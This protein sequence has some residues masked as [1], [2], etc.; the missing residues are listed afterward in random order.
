MWHSPGVPQSKF[1]LSIQHQHQPAA[2]KTTFEQAD[3]T[4]APQS[5]PHFSQA[6]LGHPM[7]GFD[8]SNPYPKATVHPRGN[9]SMSILGVT[10]FSLPSQPS[11]R[12]LHQ[13]P[14]TNASLD[15]QV[16]LLATLQKIH[17]GK[18]ALDEWAVSIQRIQ[19]KRPNQTDLTSAQ[20]IL[21]PTPTHDPPEP[22]SNSAHFFPKHRPHLSPLLLSIDPETTPTAC[23]IH[24]AWFVNLPNA[25][26]RCRSR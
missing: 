16:L 12:T 3:R 14:R 17:C 21:V 1:H 2:Q 20:S 18:A 25:V 22:M 5:F 15:V 13:C 26:G 7:I 23:A 9:R 6:P 11:S 24:D 4:C 8:P 10:T 19:E